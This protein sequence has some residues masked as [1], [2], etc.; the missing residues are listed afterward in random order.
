MP[1]A[2]RPDCH[3]GV[4]IVHFLRCLSQA[5][6]RAVFQGD[7]AI[8]VGNCKTVPHW[9]RGKVP[10]SN[11]LAILLARCPNT[12]AFVASEATRQFSVC[13]GRFHRY[14]GCHD[15]GTGHDQG[16]SGQGNLRGPPLFPVSRERDDG[17]ELHWIPFPRW[18]PDRRAP[19]PGVERKASS[20]A[21][22]P[23]TPRKVAV[24]P[25]LVSWPDSSA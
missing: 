18:T 9:W 21:Q 5:Q 15:G 17:A 11:L 3:V 25:V 1:R 2:G 19:R 23:V 7:D 12:P 10:R 6:D 14:S 4:P 22:L 8:S 16:M 24:D 13:E 20:W